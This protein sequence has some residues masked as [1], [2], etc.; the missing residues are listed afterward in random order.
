MLAS[1]KRLTGAVALAVVASGLS[2]LPLAP[3]QADVSGTISSFPYSQPWSDAG[4][5]TVNDNWSGVTGVQGYLGEDLTTATGTDPQTITADGGATSTD[6]IANG[7]TSSSAGGVLEA[8][9][10]ESIALQGSGTAD[11]PQVVFHL[12]LSALSAATFAFDAKDL[13]G[14]IDN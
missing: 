7:A 11:V 2:L 3:A 14:S 9:A 13:D 1:R 10:E 4:L 12:D 8:A 6:V 5:I